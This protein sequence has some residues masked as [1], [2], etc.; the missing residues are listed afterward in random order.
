MKKG[1]VIFF[2]L[3][4]GVTLGNAFSAEVAPDFA[5]N[6][7]QGN[8]QRLSDHRGNFVVLEW[9]NPDCPFVK[10]HYRSGNM[11]D[12]QKEYT[13]KG[14]LW[15]TV[16][17]SAPGKQGH[18]AAA[19]YNEIL[20]NQ[21]ASPTALLLDHEGSVGRS[22]DARTTPHMYIIDPQG[23]LVYQGAIDDRVST[24]PRDVETSHNYVRSAL[25]EALNGQE[26][27]T[28]VTQPYGCSV[29]Y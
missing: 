24:N 21:G 23:R 5:L 22:Y 4:L 15:F 28:S 27:S 25:D 2:G 6:D 9:Y 11:Q 16:N 12:L 29:K 10:K 18:Y 7:T 19:E 13:A 20:Q 3:F 1:L 8:V 26:V 14:V 17:S